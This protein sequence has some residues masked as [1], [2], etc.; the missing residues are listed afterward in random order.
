MPVASL[1]L[2]LVQ[3]LPTIIADTGAVLSLLDDAADAIR[4]AQGGDG[5]VP[6]E[7]VLAMGLGPEDRGGAG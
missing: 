2:L 5:M 4:V 1:I 6:R 3:Y 7:V